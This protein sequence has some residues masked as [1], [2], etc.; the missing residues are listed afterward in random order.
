MLIQAFAALQRRCASAKPVGGPGEAVRA[1]AGVPRDILSG[2]LQRALQNQQRAKEAR[3]QQLAREAAAKAAAA[4]ARGAATAASKQAGEGQRP[5]QQQ[6]YPQGPS[7]SPQRGDQALQCPPHSGAGALSGGWQPASEPPGGGQSDPN[8]R[9]IGDTYRGPSDS[10]EAPANGG[11]DAWP[12]GHPGKGPISDGYH[13][14]Q[15]DSSGDGA[16]GRDSRSCG[17]DSSS[18]SSSSF[19]SRYHTGVGDYDAW[20]G[21]V[22]VS[23]V[24][25][26]DWESRAFPW[27]AEVQRINR[28]IFKNFSFRPMQVRPPVDQLRRQPVTRR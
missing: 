27:D 1:A 9:W 23:T 28:C 14:R 8:R 10:S 18:S 21:P 22:A 7:D 16:A 5:S 24:Q 12:P 15:F 11:G 2:H 6:P 19:S 13:D 26:A 3:N 20:A 25:C 17:R 4:A